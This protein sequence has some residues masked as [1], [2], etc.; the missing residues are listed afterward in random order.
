MPRW[1]RRSSCALG[2]AIP[3]RGRA[4][5]WLGQYDRQLRATLARAVSWNHPH[6]NPRFWCGLYVRAVTARKVIHSGLD[7]LA[8]QLRRL[9]NIDRDPSR[10]PNNEN[11][12]G[13]LRRTTAAGSGGWSMQPLMHDQPQPTCGHPENSGA[14]RSPA[15]HHDAKY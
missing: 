11:S 1:L 6:H 8:Q 4:A 9:R 13:L 14:K 7:G 12:W 2:Y 5:F 3:Q 10:V 15:D